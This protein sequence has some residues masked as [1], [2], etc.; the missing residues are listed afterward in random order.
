MSIG[1][2]STAFAGASFYF[3]TS[4]ANQSEELSSFEAAA[5]SRLNEDNSDTGE[6][7]RKSSSVPYTRC[8]T[9][10][11]K[12][13]QMLA[14]TSENGEMLYS[15]SS[16][17]QHFQ[18]LINSD[19][20]NK[21]YI[22]K[23]I[24]ENGE[25]FER[26]FDPYAVDPENI[27]FPE[28]SALCLYVQQ[29]DETA[30]LLASDYFGNGDIFERKNYLSLLDNIGEKT[31]DL[32]ESM[33][34]CAFT[35]METL[36]G[37]LAQRVGAA[38][39]DFER[40]IDKL[41]EE[42]DAVLD[43][44]NEPVRE[45]VISRHTEYTD[46]DTKTK[47]PVEIEYKTIYSEDGISCKETTN[48]GGKVS[49]RELWSMAYSS[50]ADSEKVQDF[51]KDFSDED[52][53]SFA[54]QEHFWNDF[55][56]NDFDIGSFRKYYDS[57][58][59]GRIDIDKAIAEGRSLREVVTEPYAEY[60]NNNS[61]VGRVW[62]EEPAP[63]DS[64]VYGRSR[65]E[66]LVKEYGE[67]SPYSKGLRGLEQSFDQTFPNAP[68]D[69]KDAWIEMSIESGMNQITGITLD[70]KHAHISQIMVQKAIRDYN[71]SHGN[72]QFVEPGWGESAGSIINI[73]NRGIHDIDNP[74]QGQPEKN[75]EVK[76]L[77]ANERSFYVKMLDYLS[78]WI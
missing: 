18:I 66:K 69:I 44:R 63:A 14:T 19:G 39:D 58:D 46:P 5:R 40:R 43:E 42:R 9:A 30:D 51:L 32:N 24:D 26:E 16:S 76:K 48:A 2:L 27:E 65:V 68:D 12:T 55:L 34:A 21:S 31:A 38:G 73:L 3:G 67:D 64:V 78:A 10:N 50:P 45:S 54:S 17:E 75:D 8:I 13:Q 59:N 20:N 61:F 6:A 74:L 25:E 49:E 33:M 71:I 37:F 41:F 28:F 4:R 70:G 11:I 47:V 53:L 22:I 15:Y 36:H 1:A 62:K 57:T 60:F 23:G 56:M 29:T 35:L 77:I 52:K 7:V 72:F